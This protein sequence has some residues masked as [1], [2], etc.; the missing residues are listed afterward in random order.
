MRARTLLAVCCVGSV[1]ALAWFTTAQPKGE[2]KHWDKLGDDVYRSKEGPYSYALLSG[3]RVLLIDASV[4]PEAVKELG[5]KS[6]EA[7]LLTHHHRDTARYAS[8]YRKAKVAVRAPKESADYL[9]PESVTKFWKD[10]V[11]LRNSR[12]AYFVLP[13]GI[14]GVDCTLADG[15]NFAFGEWSITPVASPGHSRDHFCYSVRLADDVKGPQY[16]FAG[17]ALHSR[18]KLWT[19]Y[20]T[21]WDHWTDVGLKP[22]AESLR[23]LAKLNATV[24]LWALSEV[25]RMRSVPLSSAPGFADWRCG[26]YSVRFGFQSHW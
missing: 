19:P 14:E 1:A 23:K 9:L 13:E 4:P 17:D 20:T 3:D 7:V 26:S 25:L 18:G 16:L 12:T 6:V 21:D 5:T 15:K 10:S 11:P 24:P 2:L 22:A 8:E